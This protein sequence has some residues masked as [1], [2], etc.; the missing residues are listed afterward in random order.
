MN[1]WHSFYHT[2]IHKN[3]IYCD[4]GLEI[5]VKLNETYF[6]ASDNPVDKYYTSVVV[7]LRID[8]IKF[9]TLKLR[10]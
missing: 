2:V 5:F 10:I 4:I 8:K 7:S 3:I 6:L 9:I 1:C